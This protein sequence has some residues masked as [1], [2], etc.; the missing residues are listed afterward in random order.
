M[1][2][3]KVNILHQAFVLEAN[4]L[5]GLPL[6]GDESPRA[7]CDAG[8]DATADFTVLLFLLFLLQ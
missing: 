5:K 6:K 2:H 4:A 3:E 1:I 8:P 7:E